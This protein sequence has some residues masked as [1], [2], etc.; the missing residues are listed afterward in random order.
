MLF[1][2]VWAAIHPVAQVRAARKDHEVRNRKLYGHGVPANPG[3]LAWPDHVDARI[4]L[5][6]DG[7]DAD[8]F[9]AVAVGHGELRSLGGTSALARGQ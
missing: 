8:A 2:S 7:G 4:Q 1:R 6:G 3:I 9:A 5:A